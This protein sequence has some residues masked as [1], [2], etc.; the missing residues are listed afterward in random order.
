MTEPS[1]RVVT[2]VRERSSV[3][4]RQANRNMARSEE[5]AQLEL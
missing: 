2:S 5:P 3:V 1:A 4:C